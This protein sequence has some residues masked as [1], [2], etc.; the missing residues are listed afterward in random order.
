MKIAF[1]IGTRPEIIKMS[2]LIDEVIKRGIDYILI[3]TGQHYDQ[4]MSDQFFQ[5]L[6][7]PHPDY[8]IGVGST[9]HGK[10]TAAMLDGI[11]EILS[12]EKP[13][14]VLVEGDTNAVMAGSLASSKMHIA[15]GHVE[16]GLRS[17][18]KT[19]PEEINRMVADVCSQLFFVPTEESALNL[20]FE[21]LNPH[22][23][24]ITGNTVVDAVLRNL[25]IAG[26][27]FKLNL[28]LDE[29]FIT[30]TLHRA[31]NTDNPER[32]RDIINALLELDETRI[33]FPVHPRTIKT[34]KRLDL[35]QQLVEAKHVELIKPVGYL[36]FLVLLS[37]SRMVITDSGGIQE[38]AI[39]MDLPCI[40]LR[41]NTERPET[42][43]AGGNILVGTNKDLITRMVKEILK[44]D[45][46]Y[47]KMSQAKN[48]Y[49]DGKT[50]QK[51][52]EIILNSYLENKLEI[53]PPDNIEGL[54][55]RFIQ[56]VEEEIDVSGYENK[57]PQS[58]IIMVFNEDKAVF[59]YRSL[60]LEGKTII[61]KRFQ[62]NI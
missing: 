43:Q 51:I 61:L 54:Q 3:H 8:N 36:D 41:Y 28:D 50:S 48:P 7:L 38:E 62:T 2:P 30:L 10:Q 21:G 56:K 53:V 34:L 39:T 57:H 40:T 23:I 31:E 20:I 27:S 6:E 24:H 5:D 60:Q 17:Y 37:N 55:G 19:M 13:D 47:K 58:R 45:E 25:K 46:L 14:I 1:I 9:T 22:D 59:P 29:E 49:G 33:I 4:E 18:D 26:K 44:D 42:V 35:Y 16:S 15:L 11:E 12:S 32:L 52:V